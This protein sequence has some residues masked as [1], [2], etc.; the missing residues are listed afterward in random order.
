VTI[1]ALPAAVQALVDRQAILDCLTAYSR[2]IDR[3]DRDLLMSVYHEEAWDDHAVFCGPAASFADWAYD[4]HEKYQSAHHHYIL[5]HSCE[6]DG[7]VAHTETYY[8][9][10]GVNREG[11]EVILSGGRYLDRFEKRVGRWAIA[12]RK[13]LIEWGGTLNDVQYD[14]TYLAALRS[15]GVSTRGPAD[16]S[17]ERPL[18]ITRPKQIFP[19]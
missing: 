5:N 11:P 1:D 8:L 3:R 13:C 4:F 18:E 7:D 14:P 10:A 19:Y 9:F 12:A 15:S 16:T 6:L 17:Y 2:G